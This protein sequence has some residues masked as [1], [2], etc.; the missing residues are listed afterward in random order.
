VAGGR[1]AGSIAPYLLR[2]LLGFVLVLSVISLAVFTA[3]ATVPGDAAEALAGES[4]SAEQIA[5][6]R[7]EFG[8]DVPLPERY[9]AFVAGLVTRGDLGRSLTSGLPVRDLLLQRL[10]ATLALALSATLLA[11]AIGTVAGA[12]AAAHAGGSVD[13]VVMGATGLGL[14]VPSYWM[15]LLLVLLLSLRLRWLP[16]AGSGS[17]AHL[18]MPAL[19]LALPTA[20]VVARL[21]RASLL[22]VAQTDYLRTAYSK[23]LGRGQ[24]FRV[25]ALPNSLVP[26]IAVLGV[27]LGHLLGGTFVVESIFAWPG[28][29]RLAVQAVFERDLPVVMGAALLVALLNVTV[30]LVVDMAHALLDPRLGNQAL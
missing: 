26:V 22:E 17:V 24:V 7:R 15:A 19:T 2:R 25:H 20:A 10:P 30:N 14:A 11:L 5:A 23:G 1:S 28:L 3:L 27:H 9:A 18:V 29:G 12:F 21:M 8:G 16:V 4:A 13:M 6:I